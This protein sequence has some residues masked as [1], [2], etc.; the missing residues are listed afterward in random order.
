MANTV[1]EERDCFLLFRLRKKRQKG[2]CYFSS[3]KVLSLDAFL[4]KV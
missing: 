3:V 2:G 1:K 4:S